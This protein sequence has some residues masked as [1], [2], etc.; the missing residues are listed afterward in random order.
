MKSCKHSWSIA[1]FTVFILFTWS[2]YGFGYGDD[3]KARNTLRG[4]GTIGIV[5]DWDGTGIE[6]EAL[7]ASKEKLQKDISL[8]LKQKGIKVHSKGT[9]DNPPF[10]YIEI[11]SY[12]CGNNVHAAYFGVKV[13][14]EIVLKEKQAV[15]STSPTWS[16]GGVVGIVRDEAFE[17]VIGNLVDEFASAYLTVNPEGEVKEENSDRKKTI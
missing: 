4:I 8:R 16:S 1:V 12:R 10:L 2:S 17:D 14:Q 13:M 9:I 15:S 5:V 6:E 3:E 11:H 7:K